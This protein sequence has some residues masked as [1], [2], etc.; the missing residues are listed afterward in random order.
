MSLSTIQAQAG[1]LKTSSEE[2]ALADAAYK[3]EE[4]NRE[5]GSVFMRVVQDGGRIF[6]EP[7]RHNFEIIG[8]GAE[9]DIENPES[10]DGESFI[11]IGTVHENN[12]GCGTNCRACHFSFVIKF[13]IEPGEN[14]TK[15]TDEFYDHWHGED[16]KATITWTESGAGSDSGW[17][18]YGDEPD[19]RNSKSGKSSKMRF[20]VNETVTCGESITIEFGASTAVEGTEPVSVSFTLDCNDCTD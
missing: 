8:G 19:T 18:R 14:S 1:E 10:E 4:I 12:K 5:R 20:I 2:P 6:A 16:G 7:G 17:G 9:V 15:T 11:A 13:D 3:H